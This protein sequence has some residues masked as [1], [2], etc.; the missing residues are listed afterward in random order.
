MDAVLELDMGVRVR[1]QSAYFPVMNWY[2]C[3]S[4]RLALNTTQKL[5]CTSSPNGELDKEQPGQGYSAC[6]Q[7]ANFPHHNIPQKAITVVRKR[8]AAPRGYQLISTSILKSRS[9][10]AC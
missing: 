4:R 3:Q 6:F 9:K 7:D 5:S 1:N 10:D 8:G 2:T